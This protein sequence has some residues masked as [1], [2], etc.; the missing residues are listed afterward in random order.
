[1]GLAALISILPSTLMAQRPQVVDELLIERW[2]RNSANRNFQFELTVDNDELSA[3]IAHAWVLNRMNHS[4]YTAASKACDE[5]VA[6]YTLLL[7]AWYCKA[8]LDM[9]KGN[10]DSGLLAL[11]AYRKQLDAAGLDGVDRA[12][13]LRRMGR[14][15]GFV[16]GPGHANATPDIFQQTLD[17]LL[18]DLD[19]AENELF[20]DQFHAAVDTYMAFVDTTE[21]TAQQA[22]ADAMQQQQVDLANLQQESATLQA[23]SASIEQS[24]EQV[25]NQVERELSELSKRLPPLDS[26]IFELNSRLN[27]LR[28]RLS[29]LN[30]D[31]IFFQD[32]AFH[33]EDPILRQIHLNRAANVSIMMG[34]VQ[35]QGFSLRGEL[36]NVF[37]ERDAVAAEIARTQSTGN[38]QLGQLNRQRVNV[39]KQQRRN[40]V[41]TTRTS[42]PPK[43]N[44]AELTS[45]KNRT[46]F[47]GTY[48]PFPIEAL[49]QS[50][51]EFFE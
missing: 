29:I 14:L 9:R 5:L 3:M 43:L 33:E 16:E 24:A 27:D 47:I 34:Q 7:D 6:N 51:L 1:M 4:D 17:I 37:A 41:V 12:V 18:K 35:S 38:Q 46:R 2:D 31:L 30:R 19:E 23:A 50:V 13:H 25:R 10:F 40:E 8:W 42:K 28:L 22:I 26:A 45:L 49:K 44:P 20:T 32:L 48:D 39:N 21:D 15:S 11:Q 36:N